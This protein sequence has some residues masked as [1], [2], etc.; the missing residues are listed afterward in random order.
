[1]VSIS[2]WAS[3]N[4]SASTTYISWAVSGATT[5]AAA[6]ANAAVTLQTLLG[7]VC[8]V[9]TIGGLNPGV[10]TF[11]AKYKVASNTGT[12]QNRWITVWPLP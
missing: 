2:A 11:T 6:D 10:N 7:S 5:V 12:W 9:T 1:M 4:N 3:N 8:A